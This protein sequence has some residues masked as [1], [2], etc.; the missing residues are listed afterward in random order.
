[1]TIRK[2]I[3]IALSIVFLAPF[4][5]YA[6]TPVPIVNYENVAV[7]TASGK[8]ATPE[9]VK[10]AFLTI[11]SVQKWT[12]TETA[13]NQMIGTLNVRNKHT[14]MIN[15]AYTGENYSVTYADSVNMKYSLKDGKPV[16]HPYYN[17]WVKELLDGLRIE[18]NKY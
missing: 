12:F 7:T 1:M 17:N 5:A 4:S 6:R 16:I 14:I 9:Q 2:L 10:Q 8:A 3:F 18:F 15:I 13:A 11:G